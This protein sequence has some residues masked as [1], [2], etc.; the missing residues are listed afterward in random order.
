MFDKIMVIYWSRKYTV[1]KATLYSS[2][3][4]IDQPVSV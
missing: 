1:F 4:I 2:S 3:L